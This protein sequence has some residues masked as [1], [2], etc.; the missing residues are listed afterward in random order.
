MSHGGGV[1]EDSTRCAGHPV[2]GGA[3]CQGFGGRHE[4]VSGNRTQERRVGRQGNHSRRRRAL[5]G[6]KRPKRKERT[7]AARAVRDE[8]QKH[9]GRG[10]RTSSESARRAGRREL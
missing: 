9:S 1:A 10:P 2:G 4:D 8:V 3:H 5:S 6:G 7:P